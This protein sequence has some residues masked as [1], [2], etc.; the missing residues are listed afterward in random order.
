MLKL[1]FNADSAN[2]QGITQLSMANLAL[3]YQSNESAEGKNA[4]L[5]KRPVDFSTFRS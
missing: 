3:F 2:I 1:S 4:F 5:E